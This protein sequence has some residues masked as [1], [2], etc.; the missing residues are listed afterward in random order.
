MKQK[1]RKTHKCIFSNQSRHFMGGPAL[2]KQD[3]YT[4]SEEASK[5]IAGKKHGVSRRKV[6]AQNEVKISV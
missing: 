3:V 1:T 6:Q 5:H 4:G 2:V